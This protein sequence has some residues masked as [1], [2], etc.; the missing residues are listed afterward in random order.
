M[1]K[2][3]N[4]VIEMIYKKLLYV[5]NMIWGMMIKYKVIYSIMWK[6]IVD[7]PDWKYKEIKKNSIERNLYDYVLFISYKLSVIYLSM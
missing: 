5:K 2:K 6:K 1:I 4:N 3:E 7:G